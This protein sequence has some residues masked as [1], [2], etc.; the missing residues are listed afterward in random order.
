MFSHQGEVPKMRIIVQKFGGTSLS[1][2]QARVQ[3]I[4]H[5]KRALHEQ[6]AVVVVVSAMGRSGDPYATDSLLNLIYENGNT[7]PAREQDLLLSCGEVISAVTLCSMLHAEGIASRVLTGAQAGIRT[8]TRFGDAR[9]LKVDATR[10]REII[11]RGE[12]AIVTGFQGSTE[13][14]EITTLGRGGSDTTATAL[15]A[16]LQAELVEIYTDVV[17]ILTADPKIVPDA[18]QL[19]AVS[20]AEV[21]NMANYGAKV[22]HPRAVE[23]AMHARIPLRIRS[24][25]SMNEGTLVT[26]TA[27]VRH[28]GEIADRY[29]TG[30]AH[31]TDLTQIQVM[32]EDR[33]LD[34]QVQVFRAMAKAGISVDFINVN[35]SGVVYTVSDRVAAKAES[36]LL[37]LGYRPKLVS[38]CAKI[39][40]IGGGIN[41]V[42]GIMSKIV[43]ALADHH[44][45]ILQ[46]ADSNTTI[47]VLVNRSDME[48][49]LRALHEEF[50]LAEG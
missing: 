4:Q 32:A 18:K 35:P 23:I 26:D 6:Y 41:G 48:T 44:I 45:S 31:T 1:T 24:T 11:E 13:D 15:G 38:G 9:I 43:S 14:G 2:A 8:D 49:A 50:A 33:E 25:F 17:G 3:A 39:A 40:V 34:L 30:I 37:E 19:T 16:A 46:S 27:A 29:V 10:L 12:V 36:V 22:I 20:Y 47:W 7:L 5:I 28:S 42:P 21:C